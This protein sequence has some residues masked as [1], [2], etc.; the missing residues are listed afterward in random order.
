[1]GVDFL[2]LLALFVTVKVTVYDP[3]LVNLCVTLRVVPSSGESPKF[4]LH[5]VGEYWLV[6][7]NV[8][9]SGFGPESGVAVKLAIGG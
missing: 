7:L 9:V 1:M 8:T 2:L 4:Q 5:D 3:F 6:S